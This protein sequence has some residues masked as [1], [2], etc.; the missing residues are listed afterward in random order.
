MERINW[1][2]RADKYDN[3]FSED[4]VYKDTLR[5]IA[6][7]VDESGSPR[8]L[9][10]GCGTGAVT[11][12]VLERVPDA[13]V[14]GVDPA[15][16]MLEVF[17]KRTRDRSRVEVLEGDAVSLPV[18]DGT[19]DYVVSN[20]ALHHM[21]HEDKGACAREIARVLKPGGKFIYG[22][23]FTDVE[24]PPRDPARCRDIIEKTV[25]WALYDLE[26]G[27]RDSMLGLLRVLPLCLA[28]EGEYLETPARW[29]RFLDTAGF[30]S[31]SQIDVPPA[32]FGMKVLLATLR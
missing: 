22:D 25:G 10:L 21:P 5:I 3:A 1:D 20:L 18:P 4:P 23:H 13:T 17:A 2:E 24:G 15:P 7:Q 6:A 14:T 31:F 19:Y 16:R 9:D 11:L 29:R 26:H 27:A 8:V 32:H 12:Q 30:T 28:E